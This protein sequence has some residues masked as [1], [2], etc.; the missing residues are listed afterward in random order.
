[1]SAEL[2]VTAW[3]LPIGSLLG[4]RVLSDATDAPYLGVAG[5]LFALTRMPVVS[6]TTPAG[7]LPVF[8][9]IVLA[10]YLAGGMLLLWIARRK[11]RGLRKP[12]LREPRWPAVQA[13]IWLTCVLPGCALILSGRPVAGL[14][15]LFAGQLL[16]R[17]ARMQAAKAGA[18]PPSAPPSTNGSNDRRSF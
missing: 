1:L 11:V 10:G 12:V 17:G 3:P 8:F 14:I 18:V 2:L 5:V 4:P 13:A 7:T 15:L 6:E 16:P 9:Y